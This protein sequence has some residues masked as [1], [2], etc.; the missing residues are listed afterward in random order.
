VYRTEKGARVNL[1][2]FLY[3]LLLIGVLY[4]AWN[5]LKPYM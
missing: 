5:M 2:E 3:I 4:W 1:G